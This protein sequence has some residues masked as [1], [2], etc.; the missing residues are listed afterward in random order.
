MTAWRTER[1]IHPDTTKFSVNR[2]NLSKTLILI[3]ILFFLNN[4]NENVNLISIDDKTR[5]F[6]FLS[7]LLLYL[8]DSHVHHR[9]YRANF[10][11]F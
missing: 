1:K 5:N 6:K 8:Y 3:L 9:M 4:N 10:E 7:L 2:H 11:N